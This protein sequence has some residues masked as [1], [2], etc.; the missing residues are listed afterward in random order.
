MVE[1]GFLVAYSALGRVP[2]VVP[3]NKALWPKHGI[4]ACVD[5]DLISQ[6]AT[7]A[8]A[9]NINVDNSSFGSIAGFLGSYSLGFGK[10]SNVIIHEDGRLVRDP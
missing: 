4:F 10:L 3:I 8:I 6:V 1:D 2:P 5:S 9:S 7:P